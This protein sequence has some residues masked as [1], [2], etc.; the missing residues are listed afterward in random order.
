M[1]ESVRAAKI[2]LA[3]PFVE[4]MSVEESG[5]L[6]FSAAILLLTATEAIAKGLAKLDGAK[7]PATESFDVLRYG[8]FFATAL[9]QYVDT[10]YAEFRSS[11]THEHLLS[12]DVELSL[13]KS[14]DPIVT[15]NADGQVSLNLAAYCEVT[16]AAVERYAS[17]PKVAAELVEPNLNTF[18]RS[19][20]YVYIE[21]TATS[22]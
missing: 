22:R 4:G 3:T 17:E 10:L 11:L 7:I 21:N 9:D 1:R 13:G 18:A 16:D 6:G 19:L 14:G 12:G 8:A 15:V 2:L 5:C 20:T